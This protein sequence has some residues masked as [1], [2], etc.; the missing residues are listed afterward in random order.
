M[1]LPVSLVGCTF[2]CFFFSF[3]FLES[4][5]EKEKKKKKRGTRSKNT[6]SSQSKYYS[7]TRRRKWTSREDGEEKLRKVGF[8]PSDLDFQTVRKK[9][10][11]E[12]NKQYTKLT[13]LCYEG[14]VGSSSSSFP[15]D[16][17]TN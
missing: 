8:R 11:L 17:G 9:A 15:H 13:Y 3:F 2:V 5:E 6:T 4:L 10:S 7:Q 1:S 14:L 16:R 12:G